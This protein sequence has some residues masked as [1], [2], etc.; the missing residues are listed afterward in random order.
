MDVKVYTNQGEVTLYLDGQMIGKRSGGRI[1]I[2]DNVKLHGGINCLT[3]VG[4]GICDTVYFA[5]AD[6]LPQSFILKNEGEEK[7]VTNWFEGKE[8]SGGALTFREG[9]YSVRDTIRQLLESQAAARVLTDVMSSVSG[10]SL[11]SS[12]LMMMA[13]QTPEELL[14]GD[15][16]AEK[17]GKNTDAVIAAVNEELQRIPLE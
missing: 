7:G 16:A 3:A 1:L 8:I 12:M 15:L 14:K 13:D 2:F 5:K 4:D 17:L 9:Y 10:M 11:K 6:E